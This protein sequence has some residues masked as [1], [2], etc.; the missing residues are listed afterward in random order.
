MVVSRISVRKLFIEEAIALGLL[1]FFT[2]AEWVA[3]EAHNMAANPRMAVHMRS[4]T[5]NE[6]C[7]NPN[8]SQFK[9][10]KR[11]QNLRLHSLFVEALR[12]LDYALAKQKQKKDLDTNQ[13]DIFYVNSFYRFEYLMYFSIFQLFLNFLNK[14]VFL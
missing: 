3:G 11:T 8:Y 6:A 10:H 1:A 7:M 14:N 13:Q 12:S 2:I 5:E 4:R 9:I